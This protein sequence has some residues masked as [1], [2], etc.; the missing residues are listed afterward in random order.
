MLRL[1]RWLIWGDAHL[2]K[3]K[4]YGGE[5]KVF[6][7]VEGL[8]RG[9]PAYSRQSFQCEVCGTIRMFQV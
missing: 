3:W 4:P 7:D 6:E 1:F 8:D 5:I 9:V 2:H